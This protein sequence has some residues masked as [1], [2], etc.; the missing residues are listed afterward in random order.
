[1]APENGTETREVA[2]ADPHLSAETNARLTEELRETVGTERVEVPVE[3]PRASHG[4]QRQAPGLFGWLNESR[5]E[6]LR[7]TVIVLTFAAIV[8][9]VTN[10]WWVLPIAAGVHALGTMSVFLAAVRL[11]TLTEHPAPDVAAAL[12]EEGISSPDEYFSKMVDE[13][14]ATPERGASEVLSPGNEE[15]TADPLDDPAEAGAEQ[16]SAP[17]PT[18]APSEPVKG[19]G[20]PDFIIWSVIVSLLVVSV[21]VP[22]IDGGGRLW[23]LTAVM[24]PALG[25]WVAY[26]S[27]L[28]R[29]SDAVRIRGRAPY[30]VIV[31]C[32][33]IAVAVFCTIVALAFPH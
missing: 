2:A 26:Q 33:V 23:L 13:F 4:E 12:S 3:R 1:M 19:G 31:G 25:G 7:G 16:S 11:T 9:L 15:R 6:L 22:A 17:T 14:R 21:L 20:A 30:V 28:A 32:T 29:G 27:A 10:R 5:L 8:A 24:V 18:S